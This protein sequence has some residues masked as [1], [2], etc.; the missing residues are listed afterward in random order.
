MKYML[1]SLILSLLILSL[2]AS[3]FTHI[4]PIAVE[5]APVVKAVQASPL[6]S[7]S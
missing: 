1:T 7:D 3:E 5:E 6:D 4:Q 2:S